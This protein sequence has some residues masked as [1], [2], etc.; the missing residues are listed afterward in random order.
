MAKFRAVEIDV[1]VNVGK[2]SSACK[3]WSGKRRRG[4]AYLVAG[5][6]GLSSGGGGYAAQRKREGHQ[7]P[8]L[9]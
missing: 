6:S 9:S 7:Y 1:G 4:A 2:E 3:D 5:C 8:A